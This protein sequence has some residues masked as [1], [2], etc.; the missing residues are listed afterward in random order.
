[1]KRAYE[2]HRSRPA[3]R[4][5]SKS[6]EKLRLKSRSPEKVE[7]P[8][9]K[10]RSPEKLPEIVKIRPADHEW[11]SWVCSECRN[12]N[13]PQAELCEF[14]VPG[15]VIPC[16]SNF[17]ES[18]EW[19]SDLLKEVRREE[20]MARKERRRTLLSRALELARWSCERCGG[21]NILTRRKCYQC[22]AWKPRRRG[23]S[24]ARRFR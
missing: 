4:L 18:E 1:M 10:S 13:R 9:L 23:G 20:K 14:L 8:R 2:R 3:F 6:P 24:Q 16:S 22:S 19:A 12:V 17:W 7:K 21:Q 5:K 15:T 11:G